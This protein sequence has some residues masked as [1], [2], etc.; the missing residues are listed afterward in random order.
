LLQD[1]VLSTLTEWLADTACNRNPTVLL[2]AGIIYLHEG[3]P[4]DAL[5]VCH[6]G[7]TLEL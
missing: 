5:K 1:A 6:G 4:L 7:A 2:I 3:N